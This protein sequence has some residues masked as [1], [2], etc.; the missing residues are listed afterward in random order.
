MG[1]VGLNFGSPT[2]GTGFDVSATVATI[3][4]NL[5]NVETPWNTQLTALQKQDTAISSLGTLMSNLSNDMEPVD[6]LERHPG[7]ED[8]S[9]SDTNVVQLTA[10][11]ASST[12]GTHTI[13]VANLAKTSSGYLAPITNASDTLS[14]AISIQVGNGKAHTIT[15]GS[16]DNTLSGLASAINSAG[17]GV[18]A[19]VL[20]DSSGSRLSL[21]SGTSGAGG[22]ITISS[23]SITDTSPAR[24]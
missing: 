3:V 14:G 11:S 2:S 9:S 8:S 5:K 20:K 1:T 22:N 12:A 24:F 6:R 17:I 21:V 19:S 16:S 18:T 15:I 23:N 7:A 13:S 10:A 4:G